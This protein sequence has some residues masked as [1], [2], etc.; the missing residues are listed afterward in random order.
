MKRVGLIILAFGLL[1]S[2]FSGF[3]YVTQEKILEVGDL[4]I[5]AEKTNRASWSPMIGIGVMAV[6]GIVFALG[7][8]E[9]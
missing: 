6:G 5:T 1:I 7:G 2:L 4:E 9:K 8:K 3:N